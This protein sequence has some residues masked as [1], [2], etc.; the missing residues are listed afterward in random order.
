[1]PPLPA[2]RTGDQISQR[3]FLLAS[4]LFN[5]QEVRALCWFD[6]PWNWNWLEWSNTVSLRA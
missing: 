3:A 5:P 4:C 6:P 1:M 2:A